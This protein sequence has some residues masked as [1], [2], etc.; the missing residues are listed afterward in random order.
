MNVRG[1]LAQIWY[2][3]YQ[4]S[5]AFAVQISFFYLEKGV[6]SY[7]VHMHRNCI[8]ILPVSI[9]THGVEH[10]LSWPHDPLL[11]VLVFFLVCLCNHICT[12]W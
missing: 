10:Q 1:D 12:I 8:F 3:G 11:C 2:V 5:R 7:T 6:R 9:N 4:S